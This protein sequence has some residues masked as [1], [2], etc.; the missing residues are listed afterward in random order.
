MNPGGQ[1]DRTKGLTG[2]GNRGGPWIL[3][4]LEEGSRGLRRETLDDV[5][6]LIVSSDYQVVLGREVSTKVMKR[7]TQ[8]HGIV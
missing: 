2:K 5:G 4:V 1:R 8:N 3:V 6:R 7:V